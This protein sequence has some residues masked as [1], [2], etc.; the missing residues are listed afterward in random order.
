MR[1]QQL[2]LQVVLRERLLQH[3]AVAV[4]VLDAGTAVP[5]REDEGHAAAVQ[6]LGNGVDRLAREIDVEDREIERLVRNEFER[7]SEPGGGTYDF[8]AEIEQ[9]VLEQERDRGLVLDDEDA[10]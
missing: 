8:A 4:E 3:R 9:H 1:A 5:G 2:L 6:R 7:R 10:Q